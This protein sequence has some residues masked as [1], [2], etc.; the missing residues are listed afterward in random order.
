MCLCI[1]YL[2]KFLVKCLCVFCP[3]VYRLF[4]SDCNQSSNL[5]C[6]SFFAGY[7]LGQA[8]YY[9]LLKK[10]PFPYNFGFYLSLVLSVLLGKLQLRYSNSEKNPKILRRRHILSCG[11]IFGLPWCTG[12]EGFIPREDQ[13]FCC[14]IIYIVIL[15]V[16]MPPTR[17]ADDLVNVAETG[18]CGNTWGRH[19]FSS[20][21][22]SANMMIFTAIFL[23]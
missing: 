15:C 2:R 11:F 19:M 21:H 6:T 18:L 3:P 20:G 17:W 4:F 5:R 16:G 23:N 14:T 7:L 10:I 8:Y 9:Y 12:L 1:Y 22:L 13:I